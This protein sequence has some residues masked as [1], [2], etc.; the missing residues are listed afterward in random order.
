MK[1]TNLFIVTTFFCSLSIAS[2]FG[3]I[4]YRRANL[5]DIP[6]ILALQSTQQG[7]DANQVLFFPKKYREPFLREA[8]TA[9][10]MFIAIDTKNDSIVAQFK[11]FI[12]DDPKEQI[13]ILEEELRCIGTDRQL[14]EHNNQDFIHDPINT[15]YLY[16]GS[17]F[18]NPNYREQRINTRL[19]AYAFEQLRASLYDQIKE[20]N[21]SHL[22]LLFGLVDANEYRSDL[23]RNSFYPKAQSI[24]KDLNLQ[25]SCTI[26][27]YV[28]K[29]AMPKFSSESDDLKPSSEIPGR[30]YILFYKLGGAL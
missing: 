9:N 14:L 24:S 26:D 16:R 25:P 12:V 30:G 7:D 11:L 3:D 13:E 15:L 5:D 2:I 19:G 29:S 20:H 1:F 28:Y 17:E 18:T 4:I 10:R 21:Y 27:L 23:I 8:I 6:G 22:A